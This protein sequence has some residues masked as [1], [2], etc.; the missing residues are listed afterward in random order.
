[1]TVFYIES[2]RPEIIVISF[3]DQTTFQANDDQPTLWAEK[4]T[5]VMCPKSKGSGIM[6]SDFIDE[7]NGYL[8]LTQEEYD[9]AKLQDKSIKMYARKFLESKE[10]YWTS[11]KFMS[12]IKEA[13]KLANIKYP[14]SEGWHVVWVFDHSSCHA[15]MADTGPSTVVVTIVAGSSRSSGSRNGI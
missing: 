15:A 6:L 8:C 13:V 7:R 14:N 4:G 12:Q 2:P 10:G 9:R 5:S 3:H 1:M 11:E